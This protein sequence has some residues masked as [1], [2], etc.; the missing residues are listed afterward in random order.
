MTVNNPED[1]KKSLEDITPLPEEGE[2]EEDG[3]D[4]ATENDKPRTDDANSDIRKH[5]HRKRIQK[6]NSVIGKSLN[7]VGI[8]FVTN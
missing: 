1:K 5:E 8:T 7:K 3:T 4:T 2:S 6:Q